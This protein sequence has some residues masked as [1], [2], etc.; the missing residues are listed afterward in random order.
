MSEAIAAEAA[1]VNRQLALSAPPEAI[2]NGWRKIGQP[3]G[4]DGELRDLPQHQSL[5][6]RQG[7][8][9]RVQRRHQLRSVV[10]RPEL[11]AGRICW[12]IGRWR[13]RYGEPPVHPAKVLA[14]G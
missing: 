11:P 10:G 13:P 7:E 14:A 6:R 12:P 8:P 3:C 2:W 1:L 4:H 9:Q 5:G